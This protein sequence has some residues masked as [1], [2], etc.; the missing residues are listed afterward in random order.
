M[1]ETYPRPVPVVRLI[2]PNASNGV[3]FAE[4]DAATVE[5]MA[6]ATHAAFFE[7]LKKEGYRFG[8]QNDDEAKTHTCYVE[9]FGGLSGEHQEDNRKF[10]RE[11]PNRLAPAGCVI[12]ALP[13]GEKPGDLA[14]DAIESMAEMEHERWMWSKL[15][16]GH[17]YGARTQKD[18]R[19]H[20]CLLTW[21]EV[22]LYPGARRRCAT[23]CHPR[24]A[25]ASS[26]AIA[27]VRSPRTAYRA[28]TRSLKN[29][30]NAI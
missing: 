3:Q 1:S 27:Q 18:K 24:M 11:I 25:A 8:D 26:A 22:T 16:A 5:R 17:R 20:S 30:P 14:P 21:R 23:S 15:A 13:V 12:G 29:R 10:V 28:I 6:R 2:V 19:I 9:D 4:L 7:Y